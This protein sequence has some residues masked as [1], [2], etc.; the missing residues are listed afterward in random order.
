MDNNT[1][2]GN[3]IAKNLAD[4][5]DTATPGNVGININSGG[6]GSPVLGTVIT[7]NTITDE[8]Q[9]IAVNTPAPSTVEIHFNNLLGGKMG[10]ANVCSFDGATSCGGIIDATL[11]YWGCT[12]G[13]GGLGCST[14]GEPNIFF[15][16]WISFPL[17]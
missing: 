6:G 11:N 15:A 5:A 16:P 9:D 3:Y 17:Q 13:P 2:T 4:T 8:D 12:Q 1:I 7:F 10:V 14:A